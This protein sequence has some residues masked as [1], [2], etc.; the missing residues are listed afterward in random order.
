MMI[1]LWRAALCALLLCANA[2]AAGVPTLRTATM[3]AFA[4]SREA[5]LQALPP[6]QRDAFEAAIDTFA[7][8]E[9]AAARQAEI[10]AHPA[11]RVSET[12]V[13]L[14]CI[15]P[16]E[17]KTAEE[18]VAAAAHRASDALPAP[19]AAIAPATAPLPATPTAAVAAPESAKL[20]TLLLDAADAAA[21]QRSLDTI[22]HALSPEENR[23]FAEAL[24]ALTDA[25]MEAFFKASE[26]NPDLLRNLTAEKMRLYALQKFSGK[27]VSQII[28]AAAMLAP[29]TR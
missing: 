6:A 20:Q 19:D 14:R 1:R 2:F 17:G 23:R 12:A 22:Q 8:S 9:S 28:R 3:A 29:Q 5:M 15:A 18:I 26:T 4:T 7:E 25:G 11:K 21:L 16:L 24:A 13:F 27:S 10:A